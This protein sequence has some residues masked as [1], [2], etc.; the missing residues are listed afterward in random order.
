MMN[1]GGTGNPAAVIST[2]CRPFPPELASVASL[3]VKEMIDEFD[4]DFICCS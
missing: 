3:E 2:R 1:P 4:V